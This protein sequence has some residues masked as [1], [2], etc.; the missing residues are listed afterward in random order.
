MI[1]FAK[2]KSNRKIQWKF[3]LRKLMKYK[4]EIVNG[5]KEFYLF[6]LA[7]FLIFVC[8]ILEYIPAIV[9]PY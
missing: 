8:K 9:A 3:N 5:S 1:K 2:M 6:P 7:K 4:L